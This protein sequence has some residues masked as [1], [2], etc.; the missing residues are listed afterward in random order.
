M[1]RLLFPGSAEKFRQATVLSQSQYCVSVTDTL[2]CTV[3]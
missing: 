3:A 1:F 2:H